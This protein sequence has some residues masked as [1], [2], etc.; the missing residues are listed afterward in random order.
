MARPIRSRG[1]T[2]VEL[3]VVITII[4]MLV[5]LLLP[6]I[7]AA[8][9]AGR[10]TTCM[11]NMRQC[12]VGL[13]NFAE[14]KKTF[15]GYVTQIQKTTPSALTYRASW[16]VPIL[17]NVEQTVLYQNW[18]NPALMLDW[19][20]SINRSQYITTISFL[21]C[22][23]NADPNQADDA[24]SYVV[25]SG[26]ALTADDNYQPEKAMPNWEEDSASGVCFNDARLDYGGSF[27]W[28]PRKVSMD[29]LVSNDGST[30]TILLSENLQSGG[31][32][33]TPGN[34]NAPFITDFAARQS[35]AMVW[36]LTGNQNND[37]PAKASFTPNNYNGDA[38]GINNLGQQL[39]GTLLV[40]YDPMNLS[41]PSGLAYARPSAYHSGGVNAMFCGGNQRFIS[42]EIDYR[43]YT[44]LMTGAQN[45]VVVDRTSSGAPI[46]ANTGN[47]Q[48]PMAMGNITQ[49]PVPWPYILDEGDL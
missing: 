31:W 27:P 40:P 47:P 10:R 20:N 17:P 42:E 22:P 3:L 43:V 46:R 25:N 5:S 30:N 28:G 33:T 23:S 35:T 41:Q 19:T 36:F 16:V 34:V 12:A 2:L 13:M 26:V 9:E 24:L 1:F 39:T 4:G 48:S 6:A 45:K 37:T 15:P 44:Q 14:T 8:R 18:S 32:A 49:A 38:I 21:R 7:Q 11:N 29:F